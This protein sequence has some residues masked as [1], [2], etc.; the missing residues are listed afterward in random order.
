MTQRIKLSIIT[1]TFNSVSTLQETINSIFSQ[2]YSNMEYIII[3]GSSKDGTIEIVKNNEKLIAK[4]L[5]EPDNGLYH[6]MNKGISL[7]TGEVIGILNSDDLY[8]D[9]NVLCEVM[10]NFEADNTLDILFGDLVYVKANDTNKV[11]RNW[12]SLP[13]YKNFFEN[14]NVPPHPTLFVR[15]SVYKEVSNFNLQYK[16]AA[17]YE[18]ML[19]AFKLHTFKIKYLH[20]LIVRMRLGGETNKSFKN[21]LNGN[22]EII[23]AWKNNGLKVP[24]M[25][26][27]LRL[28][29]R[30]SQFF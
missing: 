8:A 26:M 9:E 10:E 3:D 27:P 28:I 25:I 21:I 19:R 2:K 5:S 7:A 4:W 12:V 16:L 30:L 23:S 13:Y 1:V 15:S 17:D 6:A 22:K 11:V 20:R 14:G 18:F 29:K 24:F